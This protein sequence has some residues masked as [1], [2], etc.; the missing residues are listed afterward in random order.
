[1]PG[2]TITE[3]ANVAFEAENHHLY[4]IC[5]DQRVMLEEREPDSFYANH[6][7]WDLFLFQFGRAADSMVVEVSYG[8]QW[9][10]NERYHGPK[11]FDAPQEWQAFAG[12]YRSHD[13][14][15]TNFRVFT[16]KGQLLMSMPSG[17]EEVLVP[18]SEGCFRIGEEP[19]IPERLCF[20][21]IVD[22]HALRAVKTGCPYYRFFTP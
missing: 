12:H 11:S 17:E 18:V 8:P 21:Q 14:W 16:R 6:P 4:L 19:Y 2:C 20:D 15:E 13:P 10:T 9:F 1:M 5:R 3:H 22:G 7:D